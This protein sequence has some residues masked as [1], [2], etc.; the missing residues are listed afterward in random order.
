MRY[1]DDE[2]ANAGL[3]F[4]E[5]NKGAYEIQV[6]YGHDGEISLQLVRHDC[7]LGDMFIRNLDMSSIYAQCAPSRIT[8]DLEI[9]AE[10][11][12]N[13]SRRIV[14]D[15]RSITNATEP[16]HNDTPF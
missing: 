16:A 15:I 6:S 9:L 8:H 13:L 1:L 7:A 5:S 3:D 11:A 14:K 12:S 10:N 4:L 2:E